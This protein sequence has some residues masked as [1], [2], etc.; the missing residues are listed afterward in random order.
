M[1][2]FEMSMFIIRLTRNATHYTD[3]NF[4]NSQQNLEINKQNE[5]NKK[6][7]KE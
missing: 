2:F 3:R 1:A 4:Q 5:T 7:L 6:H